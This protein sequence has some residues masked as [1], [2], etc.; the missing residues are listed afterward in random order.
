[1]ARPGT[2]R[3]VSPAADVSDPRPFLS[4]IAALPRAL[5]VS[6]QRLSW[7][8][9]PVLLLERLEERGNKRQWGR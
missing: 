5:M 6:R 8:P 1:M 9:L 2:F 4:R 7:G 3:P